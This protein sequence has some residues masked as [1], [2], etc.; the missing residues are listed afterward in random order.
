GKFLASASADG[1]VRLWDAG[2]G[3]QQRALAG[4]SDWLYSVAL[5][6]DGKW[7][8]GAGVDGI[9]RLWETANGRLRLALLAWPPAGKATAPE[10][11]ALTP[12]GY[13]DASPA[14]AALLRPLLA[15]QPVKALRLTEFLQTL[16]RPENGAKGWQGA[17][18]E[19]A[20]LPAPP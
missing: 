11:A 2:S 1:T 15:G 5:S 20:Q 7:T 14:W 6:P 17:E 3:G 8:A 19:P 9:V 10:W 4:A 16:H 12:E 18:L 13:Y